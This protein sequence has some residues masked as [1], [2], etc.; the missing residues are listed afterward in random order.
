MPGLPRKRVAREVQRE[1]ETMSE[2][3]PT[4][5]GV[6]EFAAPITAARL[7]HLERIE[8][9]AK[10][11]NAAYDRADRHGI[12]RSLAALNRAMPAEGLKQ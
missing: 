10:R 9:I 12:D 2:P 7:A 5:T 11:L 4:Y 8:A 3:V 1:E 6:T